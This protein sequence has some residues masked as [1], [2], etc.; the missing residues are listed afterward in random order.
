MIKIDFFII[1][2]KKRFNEF[3]HRRPPFFRVSDKKV[4]LSFQL[5]WR[6]SFDYI[7]GCW[8]LYSRLWHVVA[9][10]L[11]TQLIIIVQSLKYRRTILQQFFAI[12]KIQTY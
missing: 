5:S 7:I 6:H 3:L 11:K 8:V 12:T 10:N 2:K 1:T 9:L 4:L